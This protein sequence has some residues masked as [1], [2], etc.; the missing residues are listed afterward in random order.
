MKTVS[1]EGNYL[2]EK[3]NPIFWENKPLFKML[4]TDGRA[5]MKGLCN[6]VPCSHLKPRTS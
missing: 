5:L 2:P 4:S 6:E 1:S 3:S